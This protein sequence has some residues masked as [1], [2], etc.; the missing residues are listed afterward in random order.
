MSRLSLVT[1][2]VNSIRAREERLLAFLE[3][4][5][6]DIV[7][8]QETKVDDET[9]PEDL[10]REAGYHVAFHGQKTYNGVAII[11]KEEPTNVHRGLPGDPSDEEARVIAADVAG[12]RVVDVYVVNGKSVDSD[13]YPY[14]LEWLARLRQFVESEM[15]GGKPLV[16]CGDYNIAPTDEDAAFPKRWASSVLCHEAVRREFDAM[17]DMGLHDVVRHHQPA[18]GPFTWWDYRR[19]A[20]PKGD[21]LRIDHILATRDALDRSVGAEVDRDER[22]G[23]QPSDHAPV[24][25]DLAD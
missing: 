18:P 22:K 19:L 4:H 21:G 15:A 25:I 6:P 20:F 24:V 9:F 7:C 10:I 12:F 13:K 2:N 3:R 1:W 5:S 11:A 14:K 17:I 8:L 23:K 16:V